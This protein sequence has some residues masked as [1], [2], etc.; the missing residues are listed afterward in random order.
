MAVFVN[1]CIVGATVAIRF[2][3]REIVTTTNSVTIDTTEGL[4]C[5]NGPY[6]GYSDTAAYTRQGRPTAGIEAPGTARGIPS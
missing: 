2:T 1:A 6:R 3:T 5:V 4:P